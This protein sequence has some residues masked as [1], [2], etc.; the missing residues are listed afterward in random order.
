MLGKACDQLGRGLGEGPAKVVLE[1]PFPG[2][3]V[4]QKCCERPIIWDQALV[5][6]PWVPIEQDVSDV[7]DDRRRTQRRAQPWRALKRFWVL[8][9]T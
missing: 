2:D 8:L 9:I 6:E 7:E 1:M 4:A 5:E 3:D